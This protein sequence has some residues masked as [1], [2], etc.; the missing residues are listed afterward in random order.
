MLILP[1]NTAAILASRLFAIA[2][3]DLRPRYSDMWLRAARWVAGEGGQAGLPHLETKRLLLRPRTMTDYDACLMMDRDEDVVRLDPYPWSDRRRQ[4]DFLRR[5]ILE[6][7]GYGLGYW[8]IFA[9]DEPD[10]FLG[11]VFLYPHGQLKREVDIGWRFVKS[12]WGKGYATEAARSVLNHG[13]STL[14]LPKIEVEIAPD[15]PRSLR[16]AEKLGFTFLADHQYIDR[17]LRA[18]DLKR[19]EFFAADMEKAS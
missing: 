18:F 10:Y 11:W 12:A 1:Q 2:S 8:S 4:E 5:R 14:G 17:V 15:N 13:F 6:Y 16:V 9:R 7:P 3:R 19:E